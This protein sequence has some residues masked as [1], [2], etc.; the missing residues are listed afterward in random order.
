MA[1]PE[2]CPRDVLLLGAGVVAVLGVVVLAAWS[3]PWGLVLLFAAAGL[4]LLR[5]EVERRAGGTGLDALRAHVGTSRRA[6][7]VRSKGQMGIFRARRE[8]ADLEAERGSLL[9]ELGEAAYGGNEEAMAALRER[10]DGVATAIR[11]K[12]EE[13]DDLTKQTEEHVMR[14]HEQGRSEASEEPKGE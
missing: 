2:R 6:L 8:L 5:G 1:E 7:T 3:A 9:R 11:A 13:I 10:I 14:I 12:Q 4:Y